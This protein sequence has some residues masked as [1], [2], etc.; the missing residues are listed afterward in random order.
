MN[1]NRAVR[2]ALIARN[3]L[4]F[5]DGTLKKPAVDSSDY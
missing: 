3:K 5:L 2:V 1:W 4:G